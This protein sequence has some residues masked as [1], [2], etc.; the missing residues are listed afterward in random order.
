MNEEEKLLIHDFVH[1]CDT[2]PVSVVIHG[3]T[4]VV[5]RIGGHSFWNGI[6]CPRAYARTRYVLVRKGLWSMS[7]EALRSKQEWEGRTSRKLLTE[8][9]IAEEKRWEMLRRNGLRR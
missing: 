3:K 9:L 6:G 5:F 2:G 1:G 4:H 8:T 7:N